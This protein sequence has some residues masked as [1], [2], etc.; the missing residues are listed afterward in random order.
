MI[1]YECN[2][3]SFPVVVCAQ[4]LRAV[5]PVPPVAK[6]TKGTLFPLAALSRRYLSLFW[7][8]FY[9]APLWS[10]EVITTREGATDGTEIMAAVDIRGNACTRTEFC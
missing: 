10:N 9:E 6:T 1:V 7:L 4:I 8:P 3:I 5:F 2:P